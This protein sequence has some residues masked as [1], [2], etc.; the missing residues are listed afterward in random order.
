MTSTSLKDHIS[1]DY[2][3]VGIILGECDMYDIVHMLY[4]VIVVF[5]FHKQ[6]Y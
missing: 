3:K 5:K 6:I 1:E 2:F 4:T